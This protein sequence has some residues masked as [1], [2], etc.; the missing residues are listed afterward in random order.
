MALFTYTHTEDHTGNTFVDRRVLGVNAGSEAELRIDEIAL[1]LEAIRGEKKRKVYG[2]GYQASQFYCGSAADAS[3]TSSRPQPDHS[4]KEI[5][6]LRARVDEKERQ[7]TELRA[8]VK[9][10]SGQHGAGTSS[11][12]PLPATDRHVSTVL[13]LP[14]SSPIDLDT[15]NDTLVTP[16]DTI[17]H[18]ANTPADATIQDHAEDRPRRFDFRTFSF[19]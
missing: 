12:N 9:R 14:L 6:A 15:I 8:L 11:S 18:P 13:H 7:L 5:S 16:A 3:A 4:T 19:H 10:M 2:I 17:T 1:Y